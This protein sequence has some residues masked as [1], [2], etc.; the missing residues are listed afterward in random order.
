MILRGKCLEFRISL[1]F[2]I[3]RPKSRRKWLAATI[4]GWYPRKFVSDCIGADGDWWM[5]E[6]GTSGQ[7]CFEDETKRTAQ[8][9]SSLGDC[10]GKKHSQT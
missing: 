2:G 8:G 4:N 3:C 1:K 7:S 5:L 9:V 10:L 6:Y